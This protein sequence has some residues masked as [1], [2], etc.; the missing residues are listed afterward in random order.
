MVFITYQKCIDNF[1]CEASSQKSMKTTPT[2]LFHL[3]EPTLHCINTVFQSVLPW[4]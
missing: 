2:T 4:C 1:L 3:C